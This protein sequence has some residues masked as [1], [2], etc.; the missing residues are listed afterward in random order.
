MA[1]IVS[2]Q[3]PKFIAFVL[4]SF[5]HLLL[6]RTTAMWEDE[7][8]ISSPCVELCRDAKNK[9]W[10][11]GNSG[12][13]FAIES[14][15]SH[16]L[17][18]I[19]LPSDKDHRADEVIKDNHCQCSRVYAHH[20]FLSCDASHQRLRRRSH[21]FI[22][23]NCFREMSNAATWMASAAPVM[24]LSQNT[25]LTIFNASAGLTVNLPIYSLLRPILCPHSRALSSLFNTKS[26]TAFKKD[27]RWFHF[28]SC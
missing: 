22:S 6:E 3:R 13:T 1:S 17:P 12:K 11:D 23:S 9:L 16:E 4:E 10:I 26:R 7:T 15:F 14:E 2:T 18:M 25:S 20:E 24:L 27:P 19:H 8:K 28:N 21:I 5:W